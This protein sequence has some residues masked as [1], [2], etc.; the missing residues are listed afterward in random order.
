MPAGNPDGGQWTDAGLGGAGAPSEPEDPWRIAGRGSPRRGSQPIPATHREIYFLKFNRL[1]ELNP[2]QRHLTNVQDPNWIPTIQ[3]IRSLDR[4]IRRAENYAFARAQKV[5]ESLQA[6]GRPPLGVKGGQPYYNGNR[7]LDTVTRLRQKISYREYD[8]FPNVRESNR[9]SVRVVVGS[10]G[11]IYYT[12]NH[13]RKF[14]RL[15]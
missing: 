2:A 3:N 8:V 6:T 10:D 12:N 11:S 15:K 5:I 7:K 13:Y 14:I 9:G 4:A 1:K